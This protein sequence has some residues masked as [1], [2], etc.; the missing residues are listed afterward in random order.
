MLAYIVLLS[1]Q[2]PLEEEIGR[3]LVL[4]HNPIIDGTLPKRNAVSAVNLWLGQL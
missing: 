4:N 2:V 3:R 1:L